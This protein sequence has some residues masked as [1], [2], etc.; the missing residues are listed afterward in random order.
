MEGLAQVLGAG[1]QPETLEFTSEREKVL[2]E[3]QAA[4]ERGRP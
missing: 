1:E 2:A 3:A 4:A